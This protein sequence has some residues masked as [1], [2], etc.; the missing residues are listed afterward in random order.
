MPVEGP[1][2]IH[3]FAGP[4]G[5]GKTTFAKTFLP[6]VACS[7]FLNADLIA[8]GVSPLTPEAGAITAAR[9]LL[10][11]WD[12]LL[13]ARE[14]F[15]FE[16]TLGGRAY[17]QR[18]RRARESGYQI[19]IY[20]LW[21][22]SVSVALQRIRQRVTKGGHNVP[23]ADVI[24]R[25]HASRSNLNDLYR[26]IASKT[27]I[28]D[29]SSQPPTLVVESTDRREAIANVKTYEQIKKTFLSHLR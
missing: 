4:N 5:A 16:S 3:V 28:F 12:A 19:Y 24:R 25:F 27:M 26:P 18:L 20:Y 13:A 2:T 1:P 6:L 17:V 11:E 9:I 14:S 10:K 22:P 7:R 23:K 21:L 8:A 15:G 29:A